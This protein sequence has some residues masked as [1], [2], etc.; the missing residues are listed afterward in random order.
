[1]RT[2]RW[3]LV[4]GLLLLCLFGSSC[5]L[6]SQGP[7]PAIANK[8][9]ETTFPASSSYHG[10]RFDDLTLYVIDLKIEPTLDKFS[11]TEEVLYTHQG[12]Q[13]TDHLIFHVFP[14]TKFLTESGQPNIT[15]SEV[16]VNGRKANHS[17]NG[18]VLRV[19]LERS[20]SS[21]EQ[22]GLEL[23][24]TGQV[25]RL[26]YETDL[27]L[28]GLQ[29]L[30]E[31]IG[32]GGKASGN[33]GI[34]GLS[35]DMLSLGHWYPMIPRLRGSE[36]DTEEPSGIGDVADFEAAN[37]QV[38][39]TLPAICTAVTSG[40]KVSESQR[41]N[42]K[43][44]RF[45]GGAM[46]DFA[47]SCSPKY[48]KVSKTTDGTLINSYYLPEH[49]SG[50]AKVLGYASQALKCYDQAFGK[51]PYPELDVV[52]APLR[53]G[54]G[55][56]EYPA[57]VTIAHLFYAP[58]K[59]GSS[60]PGLG[61]LL[62]GVQP[63]EMGGVM[64]DLLEFIVAHEV[65]HQ[66]W[67]ALVGSDSKTYPFVDEALANYSSI[68]YWE[69]LHGKE[70][71]D[72]QTYMQMEL[73]YQMHRAMG[74]RDLPVDLPTS[75]FKNNFEYAAIVYGKGAL[76]FR[77]LRNQ[78]GKEVFLQIMKRFVERNRFHIAAPG[79]LQQTI[80]TTLAA[81]GSRFTP[82]QSR[83]LAQ[84][85]L[86]E[87]HGDEDIGRLQ[88][89]KLF[90]TILPPE[91]LNSEEGKQIKALIDQLGPMLMGL[92]GGGAGGNN[93]Q[94]QLPNIDQLMKLLDEVGQQ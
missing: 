73:N 86:N 18:T 48:Q 87:S 61:D 23:K 31:I 64:E 45:Q 5:R 75:M 41:G 20:L 19:P 74:G 91:L 50:G 11:A 71:A 90:D 81:T 14:N 21:G 57:M 40:I 79:D 78:V 26:K 72:Q 2:R 93:G 15:I 89:S 55:G 36:F 66:W 76:Y 10:Y 39:V 27:L 62:Q 35:G 92:L 22:V 13:A 25:P 58:E 9:L 28:Q 43:T 44:V 60:I 32:G 84:R 12:R 8:V 83:L 33:F 42:M 59:M 85:W 34:Y 67:H 29:Q 56:M 4:S 68:L 6:L 70:A 46:R 37:Y 88:M 80:E 3:Y 69:Q 1:M 65:A 38:D 54:A 94:A 52:E 51:Y 77:A 17:L 49:Q 53:G 47:V 16:K 7:D 30:F 82:A 63:G 24:F